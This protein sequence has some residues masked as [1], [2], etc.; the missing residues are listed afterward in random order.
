MGD[1]LIS[2]FP[3]YDEMNENCRRKEML[4]DKIGGTQFVS[5]CNNFGSNGSVQGDFSGGKQKQQKKKSSS[6]AIF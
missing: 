1:K 4:R 6:L 2:H 3:N 5:N